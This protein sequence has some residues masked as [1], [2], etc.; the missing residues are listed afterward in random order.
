MTGTYDDR[1]LAFTA[2]W[3]TTNDL[4]RLVHGS[5]SGIIPAI[6][7]LLDL[8]YL[9]TKTDGYIIQYRRIDKAP[10][11]NQFDVMMATFDLNKEI[12]K[13]EMKRLDYS[14]KGEELL[15]YI[16]TIYA[17]DSSK[18]PQKLEY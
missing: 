11:N 9:E 12:A 14:R 16:Q 7:E 4:C 5:K 15:D 6:K 17:H 2:E 10:S 18:V 1:I 3:I 8:G 13:K